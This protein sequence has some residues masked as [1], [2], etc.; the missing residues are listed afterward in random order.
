MRI[1]DWMSPDPVTVAPSDSVRDA[2]RL[3]QHYGIR[4]L[5]VVERDRV[6]GVVSDRDVRIDDVRLGQVAS[7]RHVEDLL[8][9]GRS[10]A[11][12]MSAPPHTITEDETME[13]AARL[14]LSRRISAL[15]V[16]TAE[17]ALVGMVTTTD[18]LLATLAS[19]AAS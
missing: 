14:M 6:V 17:G 5:P 7:P 18:C 2:R 4:H 11:A 12:V 9:A 10:V 3:L 16:V 15:P 19:T 13:A 1:R 8:G